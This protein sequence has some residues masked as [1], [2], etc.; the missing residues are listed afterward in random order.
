MTTNYGK[1]ITIFLNDGLPKG[2]REV[3]IDQ[4]SGKA[5][6]SPRSRINDLISL[7]PEIRE[8][9]CVY[10]LIGDSETGDLKDIYVGETD[11]F[12]QRI[13][14]HESK[15]DWWQEVVLFVST[16][17]SLTKTE[18]EYLESVC[19]SR[20]ETIGKCVLRNGNNPN[21]PTIPRENI[22]GLEM[23]Y[24]NI[25][26]IMPLLGYD[27]FVQ[28][29]AG[30][31]DAQDEEL[32]EFI[33]KKSDDRIVAH[34]LLMKDGKMK[35]LKGSGAELVDVESFKTHAYWKLKQA[36]LKMG[37]LVQQGDQLIFTDDYVFDSPSAAAAVIKARPAAG[38]IEWRAKNGKT[39]KEILDKEIE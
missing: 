28:S 39:L 1:K 17:K 7:I 25:S 34:G 8:A 37:R 35:V 22:P 14:D 5:I 26:L 19:V 6:C 23:F 32:P 13:K 15:K 29:N 36:L 3:G 30:Q 4:W 33:C 12:L 2:I 18:I 24:E 10:F 21:I 38:P 11:G 20:L 16:N 31:K 9:V 27:I